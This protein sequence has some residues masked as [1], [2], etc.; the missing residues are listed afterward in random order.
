[1]VY[2]VQKFR[3]YLLATPFTFFVDHQALMYLVNKPVIQGRVSRWLI[4]LQEFKFKIIVKPGKNHV[5]ADQL[6]RI[7]SGEAVGGGIN[8][9]FPDTHLFQIAV[10][11]AWYEKIGQYLS[12]DTFP[13]DMPTA[14]GRKIA[15]KS[16]TFQLIEGLLYKLGP[17]GILRRCVMEEEI[18]GVLKESLEGV[19]GGHMGPDTTARK[20]LLAGL[21]WPTLYADAKEWVLSCDTCQRASKPL[22]RDFMPLFPSQ[23]Q[24]LFER[25]GL[26]F[27]GPLPT[28]KTHRCKYIVVAT[29]YLTKWIEVR[30]LPDNTALST[31]RFLY[32]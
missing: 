23:P 4:L 1:M 12:T 16:S 20:V 14:E 21:W 5:I 13:H 31:A 10:L 22:K 2:A 15:L 29:E 18:P 27:V 26:D 6:S 24:E 32:E 28:S 8:E 19:A 3:H 30:A 11:P 25:W 7:K 17:D 9:D